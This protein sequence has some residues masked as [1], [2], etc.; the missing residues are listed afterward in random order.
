M[1]KRITLDITEKQLRMI[2]RSFAS[3]DDVLPGRQGA[4][5][6]RS[7]DSILLAIENAWDKGK[8]S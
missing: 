3:A 1:K 7:K 5:D 2:R 4:A 8:K 6:Q